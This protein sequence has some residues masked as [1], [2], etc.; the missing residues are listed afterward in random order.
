VQFA[1]AYSPAFALKTYLEQLRASVSLAAPSPC[2]WL[3]TR[4]AASA[5][6][7]RQTLL[8]AGAIG[9][10]VAAW[11]VATECAAAGASIGLLLVPTSRFSLGLTHG[12][13]TVLIL[14]YTRAVLLAKIWLAWASGLTIVLIC[15][16]LLR[17]VLIYSRL[18]AII[19][20][21]IG[22]VCVL[23]LLLIVFLA[24]IRSAHIGSAGFVVEIVRPV[25]IVV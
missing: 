18:L 16:E 3:R 22:T 10:R 25:I 21:E 23:E 1:C 12:A 2:C 11:A 14:L 17:A 6:A 5:S 19:L 4:G 24:E 15:S 13:W 20:R 9:S 8:P 7:S